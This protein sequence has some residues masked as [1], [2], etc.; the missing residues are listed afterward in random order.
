M[1]SERID[2]YEYFGLTRPEHGEG[3]LNT[4]IQYDTCQEGIKRIRPAILVIAGGGY[5][6]VAD[7]EKEPVALAYMNNGFNAFSL[8][9]SIAPVKYP[10]QLIEACMAM[11]YIKENADKYYVDKDMVA[12][13]GFSAGGHLCGMLATLNAEQVVKDA[14][15]ERAKLC[16]P[17]AVVLSYAVLTSGGKAHRG[18]FHNL[19]G[20]NEELVKYLSLEYKVTESCPP[21]FIWCTA[22]DNIVPSENSLYMAM[23]YKKAN[24]PFELHVFDN[25]PHG[26]SLAQ[27][28]TALPNRP[29][30]INTHVE[31]WFVLSCQWLENRGLKLKVLER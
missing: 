10:S 4:Y 6:A 28:K 17:D 2:L 15:G 14:L 22:D 24:V 29:D 12:A 7:R 27:L 3:Y 9:Y 25:G 11:A 23:A 1:H 5:G 20:G 21:A 19:C 30:L 18:S 13:I 31:N 8:D 16:R 26:L